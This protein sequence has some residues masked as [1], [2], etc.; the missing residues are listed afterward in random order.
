MFSASLRCN[1][2]LE[3]RKGAGQVSEKKRKQIRVIL[4]LCKQENARLLA[5][6]VNQ[7]DRFYTAVVLDAVLHYFVRTPF[8]P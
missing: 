3:A 2:G 7:T 8:L 4:C 1:A 6:A 5:T